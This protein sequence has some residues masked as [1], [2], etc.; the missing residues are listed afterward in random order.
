[1]RQRRRRVPRGVD[2]VVFRL[3]LV[4][5]CPRVHRRPSLSCSPNVYPLGMPPHPAHIRPYRLTLV[6]RPGRIK[7][8]MHNMRRPRH[9]FNGLRYRYR[10][11]D[12]RR[13]APGC[14]LARR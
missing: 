8:S 3:C 9:R 10:F 12:N 6:R 7:S 4:R 11:H 5:G 2:R 14:P 1:M 13:R